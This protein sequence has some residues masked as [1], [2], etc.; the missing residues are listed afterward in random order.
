MKEF[1]KFLDF[2][3][4]SSIGYA[5]DLILS[6]FYQKE[7]ISFRSGRN[8]SLRNYAEILPSISDEEMNQLDPSGEKYEHWD[9]LQ[10][11]IIEEIDNRSGNAKAINAYM[12]SILQPLIRYSSGAFDNAAGNFHKKLILYLVENKKAIQNDDYIIPEF[13]AWVWHEAVEKG[14]RNPYIYSD[15]ER[16][17]VVNFKGDYPEEEQRCRDALLRAL[18]EEMALTYV[19]NFY[20][21]LKHLAIILESCLLDNNEEYDLF[22]YQNK[23]G[24]ILAEEIRTQE[25]AIMRRWN[26]DYIRRLTCFLRKLNSSNPFSGNY[27]KS[28]LLCGSKAINHLFYVINEET[29]WP[30]GP[31]FDHFTAENTSLLKDECNNLILSAISQEERRHAVRQMIFT[32]HQGYCSPAYDAHRVVL[33]FLCVMETLF[34]SCPNPICIRELCHELGFDDFVDDMIDWKVNDQDYAHTIA[35]FEILDRKQQEPVLKKICPQCAWEKCR[36]RVAQIVKPQIDRQ[37]KSV[38]RNDREVILGLYQFKLAQPYFEALRKFGIL[39]DDYRYIGR[40]PKCFGWH[41]AYAA[42]IIKRH[43]GLTLTQVNVILDIHNTT[44]MRDYSRED[45]HIIK[46]VFRDANL[47]YSLDIED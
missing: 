36:W 16:Y 25:M 28:N 9:D 26:M 18:G 20:G 2:A 24:S 15:Y 47:D 29:H 3:Q 8:I 41:I 44:S 19:R 14:N 6:S 42:A 10:N 32:L 40:N 5:F 46:K 38:N 31:S 7:F 45:L 34:Y 22:Y 17:S 39:Y 35:A 23:Y 30:Q 13:I 4:R 11:E 12:K 37:K 33:M 21:E 1:D 27:L 43:S